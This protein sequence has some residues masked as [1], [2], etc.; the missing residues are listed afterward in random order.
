MKIKSIKPDR[1]QMK[2]HKERRRERK[3]KQYYI[4]STGLCLIKTTLNKGTG[5]FSWGLCIR[6]AA[7]PNTSGLRAPAIS[8]LHPGSPFPDSLSLLFWFCSPLALTGLDSEIPVT[9]ESRAAER[10]R[11]REA[12][13][14]CREI[15][16]VG[17]GSHPR[18]GVLQPNTA[19]TGGQEGARRPG[20]FSCGQV[21]NSLLYDPHQPLL[22]LHFIKSLGRQL[23]GMV[24][25]VSPV[26]VQCSLRLGQ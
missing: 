9:A 19:S 8:P 17:G 13:G 20:C 7:L 1:P 4:L 10:G 21:L 5:T 12:A 25:R 11:P 24:P 16:E 3:E 22:C 23:Q 14:G 6:G 2:L 26:P 18:L 15:Q